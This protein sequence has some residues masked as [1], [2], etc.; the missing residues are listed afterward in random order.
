MVVVATIQMLV[1]FIYGVYFWPTLIYSVTVRMYW[2]ADSGFCCL[3]LNFTAVLLSCWSEKVT[4][5]HIDTLY[6]SPSVQ[7]VQVSK[8]E[9]LYSTSESSHSSE[10]RVTRAIAGLHCSAADW[11]TIQHASVTA[12]VGWHAWRWWAAAAVLVVLRR[13]RRAVPCGTCALCWSTSRP[14]HPLDSEEP[15][16]HLTAGSQTPSV[17]LLTLVV[18]VSWLGCVRTAADHRRALA[19]EM[20]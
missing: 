20:L 6:L 8:S 16:H 12:V 18:S 1:R 17:P 5:A 7:V 14:G 11:L 13:H 19:G 4:P 10:C 15:A 9:H 2:H 3:L